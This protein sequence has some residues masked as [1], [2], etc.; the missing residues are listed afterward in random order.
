MLK[1][2]GGQAVLRNFF[3]ILRPAVVDRMMTILRNV[4][5]SLP[6][7]A[8][9]STRRNLSRTVAARGPTDD[10]KPMTNAEQ[11]KE[12]VVNNQRRGRTHSSMLSRSKVRHKFSRARLQLSFSYDIH[13]LQGSRR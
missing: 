3:A 4:L 9:H 1:G 12:V 8:A 2:H 7:L 6:R 11:A 13:G 5:C 10:A